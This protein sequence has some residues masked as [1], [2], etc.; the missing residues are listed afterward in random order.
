MELRNPDGGGTD[1]KLLRHTKRANL[2]AFGA[3][4]PNTVYQHILEMRSTLADA[5]EMRMTS[6]F[7]ERGPIALK[8]T[9]CMTATVLLLK[10]SLTPGKY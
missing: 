7:P 9:S 1:E 5:N 4:R 2:D 10:K 6:P 3:R 8:D